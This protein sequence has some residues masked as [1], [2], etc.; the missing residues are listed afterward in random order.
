MRADPEL[1][2][3]DLN[4][5]LV[6]DVFYRCRSTTRAAQTQESISLSSGMSGFSATKD[7]CGYAHLCTDSFTITTWL[8]MF[9]D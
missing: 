8:R 1:R 5:L 2:T 4:L 6:F 3:I 9:S 7:T